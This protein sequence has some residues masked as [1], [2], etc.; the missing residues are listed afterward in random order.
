MDKEIEKK[1]QVN[2]AFLGTIK[3]KKP[4]KTRNRLFYQRNRK[5][6]FQKGRIRIKMWAMYGFAWLGPSKFYRNKRMCK[7][8]EKG[9][10][11]FGIVYGAV[12]NGSS[13]GRMWKK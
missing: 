7:F 8:Y 2:K 5:L 10:K 9:K 4:K 13:N 3:K 1:K 6:F 11:N 12:F